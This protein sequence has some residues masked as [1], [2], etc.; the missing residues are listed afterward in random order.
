MLSFMRMAP[1]PPPGTPLH[2]SLPCA[3]GVSGHPQAALVRVGS[4]QP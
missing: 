4:G 2:A 3:P 1:T